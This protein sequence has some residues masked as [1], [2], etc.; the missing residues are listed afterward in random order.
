MLR[1]LDRFARKLLDDV[2][3]LEIPQDLAERFGPYAD[4]AVAFVREVLGAD[5]QP[6]QIAILQA[7]V[8]NPRIAW[9]AGHGVGKTTTLAWLL[10][11]WLCTRP[12]SR[13]LV[14]APAF[15][16]QVGRYLFPEVRKW[17]RNAPEPLPVKVRAN[18]VEVV[19]FEREWFAIGIQAMDSSKVEGAHAE[20]L[21]VLAD[22]AK[23]LDAEVIAALHGTQTDAAGDRL[24]VLA[25]VPGGP[26]GPF[27]DVF[28]KGSG[29]WK[30]F[31]KRASDSSL[32]SPT[33]I[34]ERALEWGDQSPLYLAR[35]E[36][37]FPDESEGTLY[38]L[39]DLEA[40]V[41]REIEEDESAR[42]TF[43][44]DI[45]RF[46]DDRSAIA[47]WKGHG[48]V[49]VTTRRSLDTMAVAS[50][51]ASEINRRTPDKVRI[52]EIGI[53]SG[54]VDRL[55]Q[56]GHYVDSVNVAPSLPT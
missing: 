47:V 28:R 12:Y 9:R 5:P 17:A 50:W 26:S 19:G 13:V 54:V 48:L 8:A 16:R 7:A 6:Y 51:I 25:S 27:Y 55:K 31:H 33:W 40:A 49:E 24:Y 34:A 29:L 35:V 1:N 46:G 38:R 30:T 45:A 43:G 56:M 4:D 32:V 14:L 2:R 3:S 23:G 53:G 18:T 22:E 15:E 44:V 20:N 11:W 10:L 41:G 36:G 39:A 21:L 42:I 52:D 37:E